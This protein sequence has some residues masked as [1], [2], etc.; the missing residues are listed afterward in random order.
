[1][2]AQDNSDF[3][4]SQPWMI[5][6]NETDDQGVSDLAEQTAQLNLG[7]SNG[8]EVAAAKFPPSWSVHER[9]TSDILHEAANRV[10]A[11]LFRN[12]SVSHPTQNHTPSQGGPSIRP[13]FI[14]AWSV[15]G[16]RRSTAIVDAKD[17]HGHVPK[18]EYDKIL[19]DMS[20]SKV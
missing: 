6:L 4:L 11:E 7:H 2:A 17:H 5:F 10:S 15:D 18:R 14:I 1:M 20:E 3:T 9:V 19:R 16:V 8:G 13:D 12:V